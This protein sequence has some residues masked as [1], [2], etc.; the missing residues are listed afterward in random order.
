M[1]QL[2]F[3]L[4]LLVVM[5]AFLILPQRKKQK[6]HADLL[7]S[8][9][10]GDE[11]M[12]TGGIYGGVTEIDGDDLF[13][14]IAPDIEIKVSKRAVADRVYRASG[15]AASTAKPAPKSVPKSASKSTPEPAETDE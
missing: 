11:V 5:Y 2:I 9:A 6:A 10:P 1:A 15:D 4:L 7:G 3:P 12:T 14:E 13:L 8:L